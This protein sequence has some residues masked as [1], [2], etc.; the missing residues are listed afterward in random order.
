[1]S[2]ATLD[3]GMYHQPKTIRL[4]DSVA[5]DKALCLWLKKTNKQKKNE[6]MVYQ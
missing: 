5:L 6:W 3:M 4:G 1:M 2:K